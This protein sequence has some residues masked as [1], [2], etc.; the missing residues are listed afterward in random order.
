M[1]FLIVVWFIKIV[2]ST[3]DEWISRINEKENKAV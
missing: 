1:K 2:I 3:V